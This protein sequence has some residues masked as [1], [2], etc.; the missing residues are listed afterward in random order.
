MA[1]PVAPTVA[2]LCTEAYR[3]CGIL[4]PSTEQLTRAENEWFE[5]VKRDLASRKAWHSVEETLVVI[6]QSYLQV[7]AMPQPLIRIQRVRFYRGTRTGAA[8]AGG[9][10]TITIAAGTGNTQD[11]GRKIFL[12][13]GTGVAQ[14]GRII[15]VVGDLYTISCN[16]D[17]TPVSGTGYMIAEIERTVPGPERDFSLH[18]INPST[19][20]LAWDF[21][22]HNLRFWPALDDA[23]QY[24][25]E[26]D[27]TV[28]LS[29]VDR[30]DARITRLMR[31]WREPLVR[32][33]MV[34][35]KEDQD[36]DQIDRD[37]RKFEKATMN[38]MRQDVR[39]RL[40]G[41]TPGFRSIGGTVRRR[42]F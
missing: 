9:A 32:G 8:T 42:R 18:G 41:E 13:S 10:S 25:L 28:D 20:L 22:E 11:R 26:L 15:T 2:T 39:K 31:E 1:V 23:G 40:R 37:E 21:I 19:M 17:I 29:L 27:G 24:A 30:T 36:D 33:L 6:P 16:W 35:I 34:Y 4:S 14:A 5:P 7:Y 12:T 3:R 38:V